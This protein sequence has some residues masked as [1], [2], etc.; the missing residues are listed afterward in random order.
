MDQKRQEELV[1]KYLSGNISLQERGALLSWAEESEDNKQFFDEM[2]QLW[3]SVEEEEVGFD[4]NMDSAWQKI[5]NKTVPVQQNEIEETSFSQKA[6]I[7]PIF[8]R[9]MFL[10]IAAAVLF[11]IVATYLW[12]SQPELISLRTAAN[13]ST[14]IDLPDGTKIWLNQNSQLSYYIPFKERNVKLEGEAFFEVERM[15]DSPFTITGGETKTRV[16]GTSFNVRAYANEDK[17]T[18]TV[19]SGKVQFEMDEESEKGVILEKG[20]AGVFAKNIKNIE[21][22]TA[23][24]INVLSWKTKSLSFEDTPLKEVCVAMERHF[25]I[26]IEIKNPA[27][28][29]CNFSGIYSQPNVDDLVETLEFSMNVNIKGENKVYTVSGEGCGK[30][31]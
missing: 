3:A 21:K 8:R 18:V 4:V 19:T 11:L 13:E 28:E 6:K 10:R 27:L 30:G 14:Q 1:A 22:I 5:A 29:L 25:G 23:D 31:N 2:I 15:E 12:P 17:V 26:K 9:N 24:D 20:D 16:L 7:R